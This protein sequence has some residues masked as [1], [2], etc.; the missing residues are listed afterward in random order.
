MENAPRDAA[1]EPAPAPAPR[2]GRRAPEPEPLV[3]PGARFEGVVAF[4]GFARVDGAVTGSVV[5]RGRLVISETARVRA[6]IDVD[7]LVVAGSFE[8]QAW[9]RRRIELLP[10]AKV[11]GEL[12]SPRLSV[13][14]GSR[15]DGRCETA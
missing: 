12:R 11:C 15:V 10:T 14:D 6:E 2:R 5:G 4:R 9:A 7:E 1:S 3:G 8:G 13:A